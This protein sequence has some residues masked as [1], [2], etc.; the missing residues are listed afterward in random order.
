MHTLPL[1]QLHVH[2]VWVRVTDTVRAD[3]LH[4]VRVPPPVGRGSLQRMVA[5]MVDG[6][7]QLLPG[8]VVATVRWSMHADNLS[9]AGAV[10][11]YHRPPAFFSRKTTRATMATKPTIPYQFIAAASC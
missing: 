5:G 4:D 1:E 6:A 3:A 10:E 9:G 11:V 8:L 7:G 2:V